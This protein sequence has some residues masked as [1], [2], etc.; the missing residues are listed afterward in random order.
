[1]TG[2]ELEAG[3]ELEGGPFALCW[4]PYCRRLLEAGPEIVDAEGA[5][6]MACGAVCAIGPD[7]TVTA[8]TREQL[9]AWRADEAISRRFAARCWHRQ[10]LMLLAGRLA[11]RDADPDR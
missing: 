9:A 6:C 11:A 10:E 8:P 5:V 7:R 1:M 2:G 4:N 3:G